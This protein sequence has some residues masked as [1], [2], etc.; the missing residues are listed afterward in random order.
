MKPFLLI[1]IL[2][3]SSFSNAQSSY[4]AYRNEKTVPPYGLSKVKSEITK[5]EARSKAHPSNDDF[6]TVGLTPSEF[7]GLSV[8]EKFTYC[9]IHGEQFAQNCAIMPTIPDSEHKI[10]GFLPEAF[11]DSFTWSQ[12]QRDFLHKH[13]TEVIALLRKTLHSKTHIGVNL[14]RAIVEIDGYELIPDLVAA[15]EA[16]PRDEDIFTVLMLLMKDGKYKPFLQSQTY[17]KLYKGDT[18]SYRS[19][20]VAN[21]ENQAL[22]IQRATD[23]YKSR[24]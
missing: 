2:S 4:E 18:S 19:F 13:R 1:A 20:V 9:M 22:T 24:M 12:R 3:A 5:A 16:D 21:P 15:H 23:Y 10:V 6:F 11:E 8:P 17:K 7:N 14:K